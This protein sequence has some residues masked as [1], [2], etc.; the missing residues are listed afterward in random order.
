M[1]HLSLLQLFAR[2]SP[3]ANFTINSAEGKKV[4]IY[5]LII[6]YVLQIVYSLFCTCISFLLMTDE[7]D[8]I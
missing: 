6:I 2:S 8:S 4:R 3:L 1:F 5:L 7:Y